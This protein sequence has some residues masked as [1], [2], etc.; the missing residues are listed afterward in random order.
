M[1]LI[2]KRYLFII[3]PENM[4]TTFEY[5]RREIMMA[6]GRVVGEVHNVRLRAAK[7][8]LFLAISVLVER[9]RI[10][11]PYDKSTIFYFGR[12]FD[13]ALYYIIINISSTPEA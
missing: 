2:F 7:P 1:T 9:Q 6:V 4:I 13:F 11:L 10:L 3:I 8:L 12:Y 5:K